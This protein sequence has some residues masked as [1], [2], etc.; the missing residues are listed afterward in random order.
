MANELTEA[1][2][3]AKPP[4]SDTFKNWLDAM[5]GNSDKLEAL[6]LPVAHGSNSQMEY[7]KL[8]NGTIIMWGHFNHG[9][10]YPCWKEWASTAGYASD[11][12]TINFPQALVDANP[13]VLA[14][15]RADQNPDTWV[16]KRSQSYT[17]FVGCYLCA[18]EETHN[19]KECDILVIGKWK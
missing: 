10:N 5:N 14:F 2:G 6:P 12:F 13:T 17:S 4:I 18:I 7:L 1:L 8:S 15:A 9:K 16:L 11:D 3:L 19:I